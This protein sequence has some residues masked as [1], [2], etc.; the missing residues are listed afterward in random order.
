MEVLVR[1]QTGKRKRKANKQYLV[2]M[3]TR[4]GSGQAG[5]KGERQ[6]Y[7]LPWKRDCRVAL[8]CLDTP[9][10]DNLDWIP[11]QSHFTPTSVL[12]P[13]GGGRIMKWDYL[14]AWNDNRFSL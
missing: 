3:V 8:A 13:Q 5:S 4:Q 7:S 2:L 12:P 14:M 9:R 11:G 1:R 6:V 10:N